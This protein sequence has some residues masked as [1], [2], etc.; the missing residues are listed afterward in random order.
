MGLEPTTSTLRVRRTDVTEFVFIDKVEKLEVNSSI[1]RSKCYF[2]CS[3]LH[4]C[5][6]VCTS[7]VTNMLFE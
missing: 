7:N 2:D 4:M 6:V 1:Y 3:S 5:D